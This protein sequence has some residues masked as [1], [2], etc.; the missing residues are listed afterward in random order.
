MP[1]SGL[2]VVVI[3]T[4]AIAG[5]SGSPQVQ[6][7]LRYEAVTLQLGDLER[8]GVAFITPSSVTGQEQDRQAVAFLFAQELQQARPEIPVATLAETLGRINRSRLQPEYRDMFEFY[9]VTGILPGDTLLK[10][11]DVTGKRY[12]AMLKLASY[13]KDSSGRLRV[14]GIRFL[15]TKSATLRLFYQIWDSETGGI[16]WEANQEMTVAY[17]TV[18][19][20]VVTFETMVQYIARDLI[21]RLPRPCEDDPSRDCAEPQTESDLDIGIPEPTS[22]SRGAGAAATTVQADGTGRAP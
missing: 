16:A 1:R 4:L 17:D 14:V 15:T 10:I 22:A 21:A 11:S 3:L 6:R 13:E 7:S 9:D 2:A 20:V 12:I 19:E 18:A 5:C 8:D